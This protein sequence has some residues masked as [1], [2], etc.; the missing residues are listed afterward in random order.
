MKKLILYL[1]IL[2][3]VIFSNSIYNPNSKFGNIIA[4]KRASKVG[5]IVNILVYETPRFSTSSEMD[6]FKNTILGAINSGAKILGAD[7]SGFLP[8]KD[9]DKLKNSN[10]SQTSVILQITAIVKNVDEYGNLYVE[11]RKNIKV[12]NDLREIIITGWVNPEVISPKNTVNSTDLMEAQIWENG[13]VIFEDD[14]NEGS[15]LGLI[16]S[17]IADLFR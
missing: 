16:L 3:T 4:S 17:T 1:L 15:W 2:S 7:L 10:K 8:V 14:P 11:G 12:G 13:K 9:S 5:D 6:S